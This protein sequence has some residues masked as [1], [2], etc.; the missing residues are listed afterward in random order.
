MT[1]KNFF[2]DV[3]ITVFALGVFCFGTLMAYAQENTLVT[4]E[5]VVVSEEATS[6]AVTT[7]VTPLWYKLEE[8]T[9]EVNQGDFVVGP[10]RAELV[11]RPGQTVVYEM[12][13][14]NRISD[15]RIFNLEIEDI[16]GS[17]DAT[18]SVVFLGDQ[19]GPY[20]LKDYISFPANS[21]NLD[22]GDRARIPVTIS[23]PA[24]A[25]PGGYYGGVLVS[26]I[27][28]EGSNDSD[29]SARSPIIARIGTLFFITVPGEVSKSGTLVDVRTVS[30]SL[31]YE[32][33]PIT[34]NVSFENTGS[35]HLNPYGEIRI[36]NLFGEEVGFVELE[37]WFVLPK[38]LRSRDIVWDREMLFGRYTATVSINRGYDDII[39]TATV[40]FY[41]LPWKV[42]LGTFVGIFLILFM[43]RFL[44]RNFEFRRRS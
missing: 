43:F 19:R 44:F 20:T 4:D 21:F 16:A 28:D 17:A 34:F 18:R 22:L 39:D 23:I 37:P 14:S 31:W 32:S 3:Y 38:S 11:I 26:T 25:E 33:G 15:G 1:T 42:L 30:N 35:V 9:G 36:N 27:K 8:L 12:S 24:D 6:S 13:V 5:S 10:G 41:V 40:T 2:R 29:S 7:S